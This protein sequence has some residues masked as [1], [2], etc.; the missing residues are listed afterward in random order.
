MTARMKLTCLY[1]SEVSRDNTREDAREDT[2]ELGDSSGTRGV[3]VLLRLPGRGRT[4]WFH[5]RL[6]RDHRPGRQRRRRRFGSSG[7]NKR[8]ADRPHRGRALL[9]GDPPPGAE[10]AAWVTNWLFIAAVFV[11][12]CYLFLLFPDGRPTSPR[13]KSTLASPSVSKARNLSA[14]D[15]VLMNPDGPSGAPHNRSTRGAQRTRHRRGRRLR[16]VDA[17]LVSQGAAPCGAN[18]Y[19]LGGVGLRTMTY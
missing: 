8:R 14:G 7:G 13:W 17:Y 11:P 6:L 16:R 2:S 19:R 3:G 12:V 5:I 18:G 4:R 1:F 15:F 10:L 9:G